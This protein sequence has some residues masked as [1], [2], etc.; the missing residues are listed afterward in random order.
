MVF[1]VMVETFDIYLRRLRRPGKP[2]FAVKVS[3]F[4]PGYIDLL[5]CL[6]VRMMHSKI[7]WT[8]LRNGRGTRTL[9]M[10]IIRLSGNTLERC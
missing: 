9:F 6:C 1:R 2:L 8:L 5:C 4:Y 3:I 7:F 10:S